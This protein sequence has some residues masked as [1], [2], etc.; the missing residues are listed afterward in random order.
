LVGG[1][2]GGA[3]RFGTRFWLDVGFD[4][5]SDSGVGT[6]F[7]EVKVWQ[8]FHSEDSESPFVGMAVRVVPA[9]ESLIDF[10]PLAL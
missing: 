6:E 8:N 10:R 1:G 5:E 4:V 3:G 2:E 9:H 7:G